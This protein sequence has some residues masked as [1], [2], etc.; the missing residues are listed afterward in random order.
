MYMQNNRSALDESNNAL[1]KQDN[2]LTGPGNSGDKFVFIAKIPHEKVTSVM[3][4]PAYYVIHLLHSVALSL[5]LLDTG[6]FV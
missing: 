6:A 4:C 1:F 5:I 2:R 3:R